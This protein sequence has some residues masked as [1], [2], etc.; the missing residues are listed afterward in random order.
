MKVFRFYDFY[1]KYDGQG[2]TTRIDNP[3]SP[4]FKKACLPVGRGGWEI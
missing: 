1:R 2:V 3:P 4:P